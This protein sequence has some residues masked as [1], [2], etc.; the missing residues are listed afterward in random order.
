[1]R[2]GPQRPVNPDAIVWRRI[3]SAHWE[4]VLKAL[5]GEHAERTGSTL[6]KEMLADWANARA[7]FWQICPKEMLTRLPQPLEDNAAA[8]AAE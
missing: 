3:A 5:I 6:A 2:I 7:H 4:S 1:M 8:V